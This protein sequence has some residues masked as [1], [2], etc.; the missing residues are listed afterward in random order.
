MGRSVVVPP[1]AIGKRLANGWRMSVYVCVPS[2]RRISLQK[3][4]SKQRRSSEQVES[5]GTGSNFSDKPRDRNGS[6][7]HLG[8]TRL[9]LKTKAKSLARVRSAGTLPWLGFDGVQPNRSLL[10]GKHCRI[11]ALDGVASTG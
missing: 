2:A 6:T 4:K 3:T 10:P 1:L 8:R 11:N 5:A 9:A 7:Q